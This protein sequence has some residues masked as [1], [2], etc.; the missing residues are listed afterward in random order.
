MLSYLKLADVRTKAQLRS[1]WYGIEDGGWRW[2]SKQAAAVL[3]VPA[4][5]A[6]VFEVHLFF[7][8]DYQ[9]RAGGPVT[10]SV[11]LDGRPLTHETYSQPGGYSL[12]IAVPRNRLTAP[13]A[14]VALQLN[15][16]M[17]PGGNEKRELGA[18]VSGFGFVA[19]Q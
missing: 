2:M 19:P 4:D 10:L 18:V 6:P 13:D 15:R 1:G 17:P 16:A 5:A 9:Q 8:P 14:T 3:R 7:P 11:L 12:S